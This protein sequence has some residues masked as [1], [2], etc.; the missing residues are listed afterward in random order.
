MREERERERLEDKAR[1]LNEFEY[2][3]DVSGLGDVGER[4]LAT[5]SSDWDID[6]D[7]GQKKDG[8]I[9][10]ARLDEV[11]SLN[12]SRLL[13]NFPTHT[14]HP[15]HPLHPFQ[16]GNLLPDD[17]LYHGSKGYTNFIRPD[18]NANRS[19]KMKAGPIKATS[20]IRT[21]TVVD[22]QPDVCK[23]YKETGFC[24]YGDSCKFLHDRGD[25]LAGWQ[26]DK[27]AVNPVTG[28]SEDLESEDEDVPFAC[29]ICR[30]PFKDPVVT[31][32]GHYF[33]ME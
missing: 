29:L 27:L 26:L 8:A 32:C 9:K 25:Y 7:E 2:K 10:R 20:N 3:A 1:D 16:D 4:S 22:Y 15:L 30:N 12:P 31:K 17:G 28:E 19:S 11:S 6:G 23:D 14:L 13:A 24:G 18:P 33:D 21:I 5:R